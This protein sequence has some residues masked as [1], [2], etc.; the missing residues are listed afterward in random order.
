[1]WECRWRPYRSKPQVW[2]LIFQR[3]GRGPL[4][5]TGPRAA[6]PCSDPR[7]GRCRFAGQCRCDCQHLRQHQSRSADIHPSGC[8]RRTQARNRPERSAEGRRLSS[9]E[10]RRS[11]H[12]CHVRFRDV[13]L[14]QRILRRCQDER[15]CHQVFQQRHAR[16]CAR[17]RELHFVRAPSTMRHS[18]VSAK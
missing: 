17:W 5:L 3:R 10:T 1:M 8:T 9:S 6:R 14:H 11:R 18:R 12:C 2:V 16:Y 13:A 15:P 7:C 4:D